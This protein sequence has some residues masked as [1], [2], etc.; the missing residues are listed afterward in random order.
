MEY[1]KRTDD[2]LTPKLGLQRLPVTRAPQ[3]FFPIWKTKFW[4]TSIKC[5]HDNSCVHFVSVSQPCSIVVRSGIIAQLL[6]QSY[7][8]FRW[9]EV[10]YVEKTWSVFESHSRNTFC[11]R[12]V[13]E[14]GGV[15]IERKQIEPPKRKSKKRKI[16]G[17]WKRLPLEWVALCEDWLFIGLLWMQI[18]FRRRNDS[19]C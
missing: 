19:P 10:L 5:F 4:W 2:G 11:E 16:P 6:W 17:C 14:G 12:N 7:L 13:C 18:I 15:S 9:D 1:N 3:R 8:Q